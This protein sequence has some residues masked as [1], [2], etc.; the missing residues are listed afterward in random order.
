[1]IALTNRLDPRWLILLITLF[2]TML[3]NQACSQCEQDLDFDEFE[4]AG[5]LGNGVW[6]ISN[7]GNTA[8]QMINGTP[9]FMVSPREMINVRI[10][11]TIT[12]DSLGADNDYIGIVF[13]VQEPTTYTDDVTTMDMWLLD[14]KAVGQNSAEEGFS[15]IKINDTFDFED[16]ITFMPYFWTHNTYSG[17]DIAETNFGQGLGWQTETVYDIEVT[18]LYNRTTVKINGQTIMDKA[19]CFDPGRFGLYTFSQEGV[20]FEDFEYELIP[21]FSPPTQLCRGEEFQFHY[22]DPNCS[23]P[24][25]LVNNVVTSVQWSFSDG[26]VSNLINP[27]HEFEEAGPQTVEMIV[28]NSDGCQETV[29]HL[30]EVLNG[31]TADFSVQDACIGE[32]VQFQNLSSS[33]GLDITSTQWDIDSDG[34]IDYFTPDIQHTYNQNGT[35]TATLIVNGTVCSDTTT[36]ALDLFP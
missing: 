22:T 24:D 5:P 2:V 32:E 16:P 9:T 28:T 17:F 33:N 20:R 6:D 8:Q 31:P 14:W 30:F 21:D 25:V 18:L 11:G 4:V 29:Q 23:A 36:Q 3:V 27:T 19:D 10:S 12:V 34:V 35:Y 26:G 1:M 7:G 15:L 13:S